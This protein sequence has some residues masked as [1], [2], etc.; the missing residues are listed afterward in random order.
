PCNIPTPTSTVPA[1]L[2]AHVSW[3]GRIPGT[4]SYQVPMSITLK[5]GTT[6]VNYP[7]QNTDNQGFMTV[8][9]TGLPNG[10]YNVRA[11]S[12]DIYLSNSGTVDL[13]GS[14]GTQIELG[15]MRSGDCNGDNQVDVSDFII[16]KAS[17][18]FSVGDPG[19]DD[20]ADFT[21]DGIVNLPDFNLEKINFGT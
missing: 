16:L 20:R 7:V 3:Q 2:T 4:S 19:Y 10:I 1:D 8:S 11:K 21:G 15:L 5:S 14:P 9:V 17:Y 12:P 18:G 6:E 13:T